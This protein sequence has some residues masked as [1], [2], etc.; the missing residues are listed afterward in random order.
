MG[1]WYSDNSGH[2]TE[3]RGGGS[4]QHGRRKGDVGKVR[5][6]R[7]DDPGWRCERGGWRGVLLPTGVP[8]E[9]PRGDFQQ[10][11]YD[12]TA[13]YVYGTGTDKVS[14]TYGI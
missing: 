9:L 2:H 6:G 13:V 12:L 1:A 5:C 7:L 8:F 10:Q 14:V 3:Q 4:Q 11:P